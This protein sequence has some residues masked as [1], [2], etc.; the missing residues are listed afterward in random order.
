MR[1]TLYKTKYGKA[2]VGDALEVMRE[3]ETSTVNLAIT[4]PPYALHFKKEYGNVPQEDYVSWFVPFGKEIYRILRDDGSFVLNIGGSW[5]PGKPTRSLYHFEVLISLVRNCGFHLAQ[6]MY[7]YNPAKL[8]APAEWV[9]VRKLRV[10]DAVECLW[11]LSKTPWPKANN[12]RVLQEY[13]P[14]MLRLVRKGYK[15]KKRPSGHNITAKFIEREGSIP[16]NFLMLGNNDANGKY[17]EACKRLGYQPHPARFPIQLPTFFI[18]LL[19]DIGDLVLD[20]FAGSNTTGEAAER[21]QRNWLA[22]DS[23]LDYLEA[24]HSRFE[25]DETD[26]IVLFPS[27]EKVSPGPDEETLF[28]DIK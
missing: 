20:P 21:E 28:P 8:P 10:K 6:E 9:N 15:A 18:R 24:S 2:I 13:S 11:W 17:L 26:Q 27:R 5:T 23:R 1:P 12:Q 19:T 25:E 4:S 14:D 22:I 3:V 16:P 7:W